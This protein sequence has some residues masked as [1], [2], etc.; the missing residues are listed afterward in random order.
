MYMH[1]NI[2][3]MCTCIMDMSAT[4][5]RRM[6]HVHVHAH[7]H[8]HAHAHVH[9]HECNRYVKDGLVLDLVGAV[10]YWWLLCGL[11]GGDCIARGLEQL[12]GAADD[13]G[14]SM[15]DNYLDSA[16]SITPVVML[17]NMLRIRRIMRTPS[18]RFFLLLNDQKAHLVGLHR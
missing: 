10:P 8:A 4:G 14:T 7:A 16:T 17:L 9:V 2:V 18:L 13:L 1:N 12:R 15:L 3:R 5:T 11:Q 6:G